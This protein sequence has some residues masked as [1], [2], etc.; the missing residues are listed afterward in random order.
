MIMMQRRLQTGKVFVQADASRSMSTSPSSCG[1]YAPS[2]VHQVEEAPRGEGRKLGEH[3]GS[4]SPQE[5]ET[6]LAQGWVRGPLGPRRQR[7]AP[8]LISAGNRCR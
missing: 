6:A 7:A 3:L 5:I 4:P 8:E 1:A 2:T